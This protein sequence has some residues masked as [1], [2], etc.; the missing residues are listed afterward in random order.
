M[1]DTIESPEQPARRLGSRSLPQVL[2]AYRGIRVEIYRDIRDVDE[3]IWNAGLEPRHG[4]MSH[5]FVTVC[6]ES[7]IE[8]AQYWHLLFYS[9][10][11]LVAVGTI[12]RMLVNLDLLTVGRVRYCIGKLKE[13]LPRFLQVPMLICGLPVSVGQPCFRFLPGANPPDICRALSVVMEQI[14][15]ATST[16]VLCFKEFTL[17]ETLSFDTL[18][19]LGFFKSTSLPTCHLE[20]PWDCF[21]AYLSDMRA[22]YRRQA[23]ATLRAREQA[24]LTFHWSD[25]FAMEASSIHQLYLQTVSRAAHRLETVNEA[26]FQRL[27]NQLGCRSKLI[28][29][30]REGRLLGMAVLM[31]SSNVAT[32]LFAGLDYDHLRPHWQV[33]Q[34]L[35][36]EIVAEA[37]RENADR[38][39]FGQT[40]YDLKSRL[41]ARP[42]GRYLY[43]RHRNSLGHGLFRSLNR[44]LFPETDFPNRRV[45]R[46]ANAASLRSD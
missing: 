46:D 19:E 27:S 23:R 3:A 11:T 34:N 43:F 21:S 9:N 16:S 31:L 14:G 28:L 13:Y 2:T 10:R 4:F 35:V 22:S 45:F 38:L 32:F 7:G 24:N 41:G 15:A 18:L 40:S 1:S 36:L 42:E 29:I 44:A 20:L 25:E 5:A 33:Y 39:E 30:K 17:A 26:F 37:I 6:Q 12:H 8:S